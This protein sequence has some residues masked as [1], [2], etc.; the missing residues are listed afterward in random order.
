ML[1]HQSRHV[2]ATIL[3]H[4]QVN[5]DNDGWVTPPINFGGPAV[6]LL[7]YQPMEAGETPAFNTV[8]VSL[9][10]QNADLDAELGGGLTATAYTL[11]VDV[12]AEKAPIAIALSDDIKGYLTHEIIALRDFTSDPAGVATDAQ[13]EFEDVIV[14]VL[15]SATTTVDKRSWRAVKATA[16][17]YH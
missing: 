11:F 13:I 7:D 5:L 3:Q 10:D 17:C 8:A 2:H 6:T 1:R 14:E 4:L 9:G 16:V 12:Y 15:T